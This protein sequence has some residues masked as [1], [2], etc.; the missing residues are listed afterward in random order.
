MVASVEPIDPTHWGEREIRGPVHLFRERLL[1]REFRRLLS[2]GKVLDA[3]CGSGS[4]VLE[5]CKAG[6]QVEGVELSPEFVEMTR[7]R[8]D[9]FGLSSCLNVR[10]G[11]VTDLDCED[12]S[13]DGLICGEVLE[14]VKEED[15][16]DRNAVRG[17]YR[18]LKP[19]APCVISV[20]LNPRLW[21][22]SDEWAGHVKRYTIE[23]L[24]ALFRCCGFE[25][26]RVRFWGFPLG[27]IYHRLLFGP[28]LRKTSGEN[29]EQRD[30]RADTRAAGNAHLVRL[31]AG[32]FRID[33]LFGRWPWGRGVVLSARKRDSKSSVTIGT[34]QRA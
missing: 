18:V 7:D 4:L 11:S 9:R 29:L 33:E 32:L 31:V 23:G 25:I 12:A 20:P 26:E 1:L 28:W 14:H 17:F 6:Y 5:L 16:G 10:Q 21:D 13:F 2:A 24:I 3:G 19:D 27:R 22:H 8:I 30:A 15:G 34:R